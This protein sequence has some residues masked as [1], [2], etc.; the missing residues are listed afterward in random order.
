MCGKG[1]DSQINFQ[2]S[3]S[4]ETETDA[5]NVAEY[6]VDYLSLCAKSKQWEYETSTFE[7]R[8]PNYTDSTMVHGYIGLP[9][10]MVR[11]LAKS[12]L[13]NASSHYASPA[14]KVGPLYSPRWEAN[15]VRSA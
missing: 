10:T 1:K 12:K 14:E 3:S 11:L 7:Q 9:V 6:E 8:H 2:S 4:C 5:V 15:N 13:F